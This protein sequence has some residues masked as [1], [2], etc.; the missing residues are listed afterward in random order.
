[1]RATVFVALLACST[2]IAHGGKVDGS[3]LA[4]ATRAMS[5]GEFD[6]AL[7]TLDAAI[8]NE[9]Q[10]SELAQLHLARG[11]CLVAVGKADQA[12]QAFKRALVN[13]GTVELDA[14]RASPDALHL[15]ETAR[16]S[17][18]ARL[19]VV[20]PNGAADLRVDDR[21]MGPAP[22]SLELSAGQHRI[23]AKSADGRVASAEVTLIGARPRQLD[24][25]LRPAAAPR[26]MAVPRVEIPPLSPP[27][28]VEARAGSKFRTAG[29][30]T[31]GAGLAVG[32]AGGVCLGLA[33][34]R[35]QT[36][37]TGTGLAQ[38]TADAAASEGALFQT[39]GW[40]GAAVGASALVTGVVLIALP[41]DDGPMVGALVTPDGVAFVTL[42]GSLP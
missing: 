18:P 26:P 4:E 36:L 28:A 19:I 29:W 13:D 34:D 21:P 9:V 30:I 17:L 2:A 24:L 39:L 37:T 33:A 23:D 41:S 27:P 6:R 16:A 14:K 20:V 10:P 7:Q 12:T 35:Y 40:A 31:A 22:V 38:K 11:E 32:A 15:F 1:M 3:P 8:A 5:E 25:E 42:R